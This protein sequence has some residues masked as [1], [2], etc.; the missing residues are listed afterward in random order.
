MDT[1]Q[2]VVVTKEKYDEAMLAEAMHLMTEPVFQE[3]PG[4]AMMLAMSGVAF[5]K[6][7]WMRLMGEIKEEG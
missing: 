4:G 5:A 2:V 7:V 6:K 3:K 1:E